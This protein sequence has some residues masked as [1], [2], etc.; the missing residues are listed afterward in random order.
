MARYGR[1]TLAV[2]AGAATWAV[3]WN[4]GT[5]GAQAALP[6]LQPGQPIGH[7]GIL[8]GFIAFSVVLSLLA[9]FVTAAVMKT[10]PG[11]AVRVLAGLQLALGLIFEISYWSLMPAWYHLVFLALVV[12]A[13][14]Q[15]GRMTAGGRATA[16]A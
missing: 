9:G 3:L 15:G 4:A 6:A 10:G 12:P 2:V 7:P 11:P 1:G 5:L 13:T 14:L 16:T 8:L